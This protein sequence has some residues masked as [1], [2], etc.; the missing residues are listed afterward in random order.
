MLRIRPLFTLP[1]LA[2]GLALGAGPAQAETLSIPAAGCGSC[3]GLDLYLDV[4]ADGSNW[5]VV[6]RYTAPA[7]YAANPSGLSQAGFL[8]VQNWTSITD[9]A[10]SFDPTVGPLVDVTA[11]WAAPVEAVNAANSL[12]T[13]GTTTNK[14]CTH[15]FQNLAG[16]GVL[17]FQMTL[18]GGT[19]MP[20]ED[21]HIGGQRANQAG[22]QPGNIISEN[23]IPE[24]S[25]AAAFLVGSLV[26]GA[27][28]RRRA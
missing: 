6:L 22:A 20:L 25:A 8:A 12:C 24:P 17:E 3:G 16:G 7:G 5:D 28:R 15:G 21:F 23:A 27:A 26:I 11:N 13:N 1:L 18:V 2:L 9:F 14:V 4:T 19:L 10:V